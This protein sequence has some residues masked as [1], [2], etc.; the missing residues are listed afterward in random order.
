MAYKR[1]YTFFSTKSLRDTH[2]DKSEADSDV[3]SEKAKSVFKS[4]GDIAKKLM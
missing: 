4:G 2:P 1:H 3:A